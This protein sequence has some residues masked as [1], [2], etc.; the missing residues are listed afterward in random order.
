MRYSSKRKTRA[1]G[2]FLLFIILSLVV[3]FYQNKD[4]EN[5][6]SNTVENIFSYVTVP[7]Q[8]LIKNIEEKLSLLL[9]TFKK[10]KEILEENNKLK[11]RIALIQKENETMKEIVEENKRLREILDFKG[12]LQVET[13]PARVIGREPNSWFL[14]II[15]DRGS[16]NGIKKDMVVIDSN[17]LIG[18]IIVVTPSTSKV[19]LITD[20][21]SAVPSLIKETRDSGINYGT[22]HMC[23]MRYIGSNA[24]IKTGY[25]VE[26]SGL[27]KIY[28]KGIIIG[29]I[30]NLYQSS[31]KLFRTGEIV[32]S[33]KFDS[34]ENVLII[35]DNPVEEITGDSKK[36]F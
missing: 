25:T 33:V 20:N 4:I 3:V 32:P 6:K 12:T 35:K 34:L 9:S 5:G 21:E 11:E 27:G 31:D 23:E 30:T 16:I 13:L 7:L 26:T 22:G 17:G 19:M 18:R 10:N 2:I 28:P 24:D 1:L 14:S 36:G 15:I 29:K 8:K